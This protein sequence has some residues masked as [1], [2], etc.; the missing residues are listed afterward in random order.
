MG[1]TPT[2]QSLLLPASKPLKVLVARSSSLTLEVYPFTR[3]DFANPGTVVFVHVKFG[4]SLA[5][6]GILIIASFF[7][8]VGTFDSGERGW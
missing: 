1:C 6:K 2:S 5:N 8:T 7:L 4:G 3:E